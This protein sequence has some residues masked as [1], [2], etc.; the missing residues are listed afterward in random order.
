MDFAVARRHMVDSQILPNRV[1]DT[2]VIAAMS[3]LPRESFVPDAWKSLAYIDEAV[4]V[5]N[6][7]H[8][9]EPMA[10][11]R[12]MQTAEP[13]AG[14]IALVIGSA[15]G[16]TA[17]ILARIV[18]TVV[19][20]EDDSG[21]IQQASSTLSGL[22]VDN[23][24]IMEGALENGYPD[25][26]PYDLIVFDGSVEQVPDGIKRQLAEGGRLVAVVGGQGRGLLGRA[27]VMTRFHGAISERTAF[28]VGTPPL[29]GFTAKQGF[30]F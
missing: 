15:T 16:Y 4:P 10:V 18:D 29:P 1:T 6:G 21:L 23:V 3:D 8:L 9:M 22:G 5:G 27:V 12:L 30:S 7:R 14:D 19:V 26:A 28:E 13:R 2:R 24:A 20:V 11:A 17:A 25:Q